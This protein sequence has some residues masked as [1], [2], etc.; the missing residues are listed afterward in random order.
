MLQPSFKSNDGKLYAW[1]LLACGIIWLAMAVPFFA[2]RVYVADDLGAYHL[3]LRSFYAE[4]LERGQSFDWLPS[5]FSGFY[6]TG[7]GQVGSY[8]PLHLLMYRYLPLGMAFD[9]E[10]LLSYPAMLAGMYLLLR[11]WLGR[12]D[13]AMFGA[14]VFTFSGF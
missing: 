10:L 2:G 8:H 12:R 1:T 14:L 13:A 5:L 9:L 7:E 6:L 4:Q 3:P 11:R